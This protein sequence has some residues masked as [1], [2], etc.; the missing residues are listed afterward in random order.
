LS[1]LDRNAHNLHCYTGIIH[2]HSTYSDGHLTVPEIA[3]IADELRLDFLLLTDHNTLQPKFDGLEGWYG[4]LLLGVGCEINDVQDENHYLSFNIN[5][6]ISS[7]LPPEQYVCRVRELGG[8]GIIAHPDESRSRMPQYPPFPWKIW[9]SE[10]FDGI[11]IWNQMSEWMEGL[12]PLNK[13]YRILHPRR[14]II[15]PKKQTLQRWDQLNNRR[16]VVG[17]GGVDAHEHVYKMLGGLIK[18]R[19]FR[20]KV[21]FKS[22]RTHV[23]CPEPILRSDDYNSSLNKIYNAI[24]NAHCF[25]SHDYF[26]EASA[27]RFW[28]RNKSGT[29]IIGDSLA[30]AEGAR[31]FV[32]NPI[33][34]ET[35][36]IRNGEVVERKEG[37]KIAFDTEYSGVYR[38]ETHIGRRPWIISNH[39]RIQ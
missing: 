28:A 13:Y 18:F 2:V 14:S 8:F 5:E 22:I 16:K 34:A 10:C 37:Q 24:R 31:L 12:T 38:V 7:A 4:N 11:E 25:V 21:S 26:G 33:P 17:V 1:A 36:L 32:H 35:F 15:A 3:Q 23:L 29:A 9:E 6:E 27:F 19:V 20:Y 39:I 30:M